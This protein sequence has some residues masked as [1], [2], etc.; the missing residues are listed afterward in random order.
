MAINFTNLGSAPAAP[1]EVA[2]S[3]PGV[4][5]NL[6]KNAVLDLAKAAP[7]LKRA[8]L[9]AGWDVA[10]NGQAD[11]DISVFLLNEAGKITSANDVIFYNHMEVPGVK[12]S[13]DNRTGAGEG[14][15]ETIEINLDAV[16]PAIHKI[17]CCITIDKAMERRQTF[18]MVNNSYVRLVND[19]SGAELCRFPLKDDY[20]TDTAVVAAELIRTNG[21][22]SFHSIG[23]G[24]QADLN[25]LAA[26]FS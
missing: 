3:T 2:P 16:S 15:D 6:E 12:L 17:V 4:V 26:I 11:L 9:C 8:K 7:G 21:S 1:V 5:L 20:S 18:G 19:E 13:G 14:D 25:G 22:W 24:K 10:A 23:D